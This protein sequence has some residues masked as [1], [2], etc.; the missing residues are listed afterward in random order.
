M[1]GAGFFID[2]LGIQKCYRLPTFCSIFQ[3]DVFGMLE[4]AKEL[5]I[6]QIYGKDISFYIDNMA[7]TSSI[8]SYIASNRKLSR[9]VKKWCKHF[10]DRT[11]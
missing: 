4:A 7:A 3:A 6:K 9:T 2:Q 1:T 5:M 8:G 11:L 10:A